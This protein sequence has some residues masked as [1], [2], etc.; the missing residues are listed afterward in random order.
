MLCLAMAGSGLAQESEADVR[1]KLSE[2]LL[3][4]PRLADQAFVVE[5]SESDLDESLNRIAGSSRSQRGYSSE[6]DSYRSENHYKAGP[7][8]RQDSFDNAEQHG[9]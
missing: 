5:S 9:Y 7:F 8:G 2:E 3:N 1:K 6:E 4:P